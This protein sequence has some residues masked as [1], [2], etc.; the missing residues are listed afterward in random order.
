MNLYRKADITTRMC[1]LVFVD[2][3][4]I[5]FIVAMDNKYKIFSDKFSHMPSF[6]TLLDV[7]QYIKQ[8][9]KLDWDGDY[10]E[11]L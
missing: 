1:R 7:I 2:D 4:L 5:C 8:V 11:I 10:S 3:E 6:D 9:F